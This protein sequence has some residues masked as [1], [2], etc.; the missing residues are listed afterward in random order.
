VP[1]KRKMQTV[2]SSALDMEYLLRPID[3]VVSGTDEEGHVQPPS[4]RREK[5]G[6]ARVIWK[7]RACSIHSAIRVLHREMK[8]P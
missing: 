2:S 6:P 3:H 8:R 4:Q 5:L 7:H 1:A